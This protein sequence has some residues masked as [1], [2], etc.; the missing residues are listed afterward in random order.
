MRLAVVVALAFGLVPASALN[1]FRGDQSIV[2]DDDDD[3]DVP[4]HSP[5]KYCN[6]D[7]ADDRIT[8]TSVDLAPNPPQA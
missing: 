5:L 1:L 7:R 6:G 4:G 2:G 8:I 3:L